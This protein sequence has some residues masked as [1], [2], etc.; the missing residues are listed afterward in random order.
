MEEAKSGAEGGEA[1]VGHDLTLH[2]HRLVLGR[3]RQ[4]R[5]RRA[6]AIPCRLLVA[7]G[8]TMANAQP[9]S[10]Q[11]RETAFKWLGIT[12]RASA[13]A[14]IMFEKALSK[15]PGPFASTN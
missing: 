2:G 1:A 9:Q 3:C 4:H 14:L 15:S 11:T 10:A 6:Q 5:T 13:R 12:V 8:M 7:G